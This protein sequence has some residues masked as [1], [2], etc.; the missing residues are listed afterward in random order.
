[1]DDRFFNGI[2]GCHA[3]VCGVSL[4]D[5]SPWHITL[6]HAIDSPMVGDISKAGRVELLQFLKVMEC[7]HPTIP[8][9]KPSIKDCWRFIRLGK[10]ETMKRELSRLQKWL[11]AQKSAPSLYRPMDS[12]NTGRQLS[13]PSMLTLVVSLA[14]KLGQP[15]SSVWNMRL[16]ECRWV[17]TAIAELDGAEINISYDDDAE[18]PVQMED[19]E[20]VEYAKNTLPR[21]AFVAWMKSRKKN[22][23]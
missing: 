1:M 14:S 13:S 9:L 20:A 10:T 6:L 8:K 3:K 16:S 12:S 22:Q 15:L 4:T 2:I 7:R 23:C 21:P 11:K 19:K 18:D 5:L 17:D